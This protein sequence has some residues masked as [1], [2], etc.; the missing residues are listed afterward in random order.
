MHSTCPL[1]EPFYTDLKSHSLYDA[2]HLAE[3]LGSYILPQ[4]YRPVGA[5]K[6]FKIRMFAPLPPDF[7]QICSEAGIPI[8][9]HERLGGLFK[10]DSGRE[11]DYEF[12]EDGELPD[13]NGYWIPQH[14]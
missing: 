14:K 4:R 7:V 8:G 11:H 2:N 13:V 6:R 12:I 3:C 5:K 9:E 1:T 10:S